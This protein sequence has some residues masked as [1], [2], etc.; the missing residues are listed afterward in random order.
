MRIPRFTTRRLMTLVG[1]AAVTLWAARLLAGRQ[2]Y[3]EL[4]ADHEMRARL[5]RGDL[6]CCFNFGTYEERQVIADYHDLLM[7]KYQ[8]ASCYPWLSIEPD[9]P[10][11]QHISSRASDGP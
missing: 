2:Q 3:L 1:I 8:I 5:Y 10:G 6:R 7:R 4:A 9:P 11:P